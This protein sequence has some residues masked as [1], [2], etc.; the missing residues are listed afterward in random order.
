MKAAAPKIQKR[1][2][3]DSRTSGI[4]ASL[5]GARKSAVKTARLHQ[6]PIVYLRAGTL[7]K[8]RS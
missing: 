7:V 6:T 8:T 4:L 5:R 3:R 2:T 1:A